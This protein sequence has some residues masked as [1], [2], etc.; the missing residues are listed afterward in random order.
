MFGESVQ[1][2]SMAT[3]GPFIVPNHT[4]PKIKSGSLRSV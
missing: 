3:N 1:V 4:D 2:G